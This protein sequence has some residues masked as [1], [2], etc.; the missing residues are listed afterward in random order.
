MSKPDASIQDS[1]L[2]Y[3]GIVPSSWGVCHLRMIVKEQGT[4]LITSEI[5]HNPGPSVTNAIEGIWST[6]LKKYPESI[7]GNNPLLVEHYNDE[8]VYGEPGLGE[9]L[10]LVRMQKGQTAWCH[11]NPAEIAV[12]TGCVLDDLEIPLNRLIIQK[13]PGEP[14]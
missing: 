7:L 12:L 14:S 6:I 11:T 10:A 5:R 1:Y 4:L 9:R 13:V 3:P 8:A 2:V